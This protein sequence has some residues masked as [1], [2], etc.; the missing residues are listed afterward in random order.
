V[1]PGT[2]ADATDAQLEPDAD[3]RCMRRALELAQTAAE[4]GEVP[5]GA[6]L[7]LDGRA[8][9][10]GFNR[11]ISNRDPT[12]HAEIVALRAAALALDNYRLTGATLYVTVEPCTMCAGALVHARIGRLVF[13]APEPRAGAVVTTSQVLDNPGHNHRVDTT[14]GVLAAE[15]GALLRTFFAARRADQARSPEEKSADQARSLKVKSAD[16][17]RSLKVK[18]ADQARSL[19]KKSADQAPLAEQRGAV[20]ARDTNLGEA[21]ES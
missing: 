19:E 18:S 9:G 6:V 15:S 13:G 7:V 5:V 2:M 12:A 8:I 20:E 21:T 14:G 17:A 10:E 11:P 4:L 16:Q 3:V 1:Q